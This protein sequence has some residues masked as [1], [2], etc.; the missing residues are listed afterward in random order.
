[1]SGHDRKSSALSFTVRQLALAGTAEGVPLQPHTRFGGAPNYA[2]SLCS[3]AGLLGRSLDAAYE[4][5][6]RL[7]SWSAAV[8]V[9]FF[10]PLRAVRR[11]RS[12]FPTRGSAPSEARHVRE[13]VDS[14]NHLRRACSYRSMQE[15]R[16]D[17]G[18]GA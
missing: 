8:P 7:P 5:P 16:G 4:D 14:T 11:A 13:R 1:L 15:R 10:A 17:L 18:G 2:P 6:L 12:P 9:I 3:V